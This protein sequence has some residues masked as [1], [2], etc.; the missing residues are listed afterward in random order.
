MQICSICMLGYLSS[1]HVRFRALL[2]LTATNGSG[3]RSF[4]LVAALKSRQAEPARKVLSWLQDVTQLGQDKEVSI[5][6]VEDFELCKN[7]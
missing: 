5:Q 4:P 3:E 6:G 1:S 7:I 2:N